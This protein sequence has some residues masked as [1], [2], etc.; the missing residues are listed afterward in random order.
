MEQGRVLYGDTF[1]LY[2]VLFLLHLT[3]DAEE[4]LP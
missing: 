1:L 2:N 3:A 4:H